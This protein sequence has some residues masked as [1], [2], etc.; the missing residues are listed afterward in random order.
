MELELMNISLQLNVKYHSFSKR[1]NSTLIMYSH[2]LLSILLLTIYS[3]DNT[4]GFLSNNDDNLQNSER[5]QKY[6]YI[7]N[8]YRVFTVQNLLKFDNRC[9]LF[10]LIKNY[11]EGSKTTK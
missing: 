6:E 10:N 3:L 11:S 8:Q 4:Y 2:K 1:I 9:D 7:I 5:L